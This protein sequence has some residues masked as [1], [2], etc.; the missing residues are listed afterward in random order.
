MFKTKQDIITYCGAFGKWWDQQVYK[1]L[2]LGYPSEN[3]VYKLIRGT[4][5]YDKNHGP[6]E[7]GQ[8]H[9]PREYKPLFEL[10]E[11]MKVK[12]PMQH[13]VFMMH[14]AVFKLKGK[15]ANLPM[16]YR[17]LGLT[18]TAYR[19]ALDEALVIIEFH[20]KDLPELE[21]NLLT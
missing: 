15:H 20:L 18:K 11:I 10:L 21:E 5:S 14:Y 2:Y 17:E 8:Q 4:V 3:I 6:R 9:I 19:K 7:L 1:G 12:H 16:K 13:K